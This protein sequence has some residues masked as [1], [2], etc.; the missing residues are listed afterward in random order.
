M[1]ELIIWWITGEQVKEIF[2]R[3]AKHEKGEFDRVTLPDGLPNYLK[4]ELGSRNGRPG[5]CRLWINHKFEFQGCNWDQAKA[6]ELFEGI[7]Q[8]DIGGIVMW[9]HDIQRLLDFDFPNLFTD[10][11][12]NKIEEI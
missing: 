2:A 12:L 7:D 4:E 10:K 9:R 1:G 3:Y 6:D 5:R 11:D 8:A